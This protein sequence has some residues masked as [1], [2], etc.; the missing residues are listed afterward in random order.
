MAKCLEV[1]IQLLF[2][3][4]HFLH[5][6]PRPY[7]VD[8]DG[9]I[10]VGGETI[11]SDEHYWHATHG[12]RQISTEE[13][14]RKFLGHSVSEY[15]VSDI[16]ARFTPAWIQAALETVG[17]VPKAGFQFSARFTVIDFFEIS[18]GEL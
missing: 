7:H 15:R 10:H 4:I 8:A 12:C 9:V 14:V 11:P 2:H 3:S 17:L 16:F 18:L 1:P 13:G 6:G 5:S